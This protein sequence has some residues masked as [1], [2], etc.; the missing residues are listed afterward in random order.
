MFELSNPQGHRI[1]SAKTPLRSHYRRAACA[2][3]ECEPYKLGWA[4][5]FDISTE[6]GQEQTQYVVHESGRHF[7]IEKLSETMVRFHFP[8]GQECFGEEHWVSL[9]RDPFLLVR[10]G[11][12]FKREHNTGE[13]WVDDFATHL[14]KLR[15]QYGRG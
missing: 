9:D 2:E 12:Y 3:V 10:E 6:L 14:D 13:E 4:S 5:T 1:Y 15:T 8:P 11:G 7:T